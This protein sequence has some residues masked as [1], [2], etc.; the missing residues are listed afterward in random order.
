MTAPFL[1][2]FGGML[3]FR[4][5]LKVGDLEVVI[6]ASALTFPRRTR[7]GVNLIRRIRLMSM[8]RSGALQIMANNI[9]SSNSRKRV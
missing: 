9:G 6:L 1:G 5:P 4:E 3:L 2:S 8:R 7:L